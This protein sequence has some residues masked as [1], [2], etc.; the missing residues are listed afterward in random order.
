MSGPIAE[1][2]TALGVGNGFPFCLDKLDVSGFDL[3][4]GM[5]LQQAMQW[6][7]R[8]QAL[9]GSATAHWEESS[10]VIVSASATDAVSSTPPMG[11]VC[12][13]SGFLN[14]T[15]DSTEFSSASA[16]LAVRRVPILNS[17]GTPLYRLYDGP[18][19]NE[20]NFTDS[21]G[22]SE[23]ARVSAFI[24]DDDFGIF[25]EAR[26]SLLSF[27]QNASDQGGQSDFAARDV[28]GL[29]FVVHAFSDSGD[30]DDVDAQA[31]T[32][33]ANTVSM[34]IEASITGLEFYQFE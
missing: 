12:A 18:T 8:V 31:M 19:T 5:T 3:V 26:V 13:F 33:N 6:Y 17:L 28:G 27:R 30:P 7:W 23:A 32:S 11:R 22:F 24:R 1:P 16:T 14:S 21:Y 34:T 10:T 4:N 20:D 29:P 15:T 25:E 9:W 2:F